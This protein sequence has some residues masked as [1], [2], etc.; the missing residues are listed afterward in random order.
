MIF[1]RRFGEPKRFPKI[2][3]RFPKMA[4]CFRKTN[5]L[6]SQHQQVCRDCLRRGCF[7]VRT[8]ELALQEGHWTQSAFL[9]RTLSCASFGLSMHGY[10]EGIKV[11]SRLW[12]RLGANLE[13]FFYFTAEDSKATRITEVH[14]L[15]WAKIGEGMSHPLALSSQSCDGNEKKNWD[16]FLRQ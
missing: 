13:V 1:L 3:P 16:L 9:R 15:I 2:G 6:Q 7:N 4:P 5:W 8:Q 10:C 12:A 11:H 14:H